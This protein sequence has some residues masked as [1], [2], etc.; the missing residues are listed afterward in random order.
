LTGDSSSERDVLADGKAEDIGRAG[1]SKTVDGDIVR[2]FLLL[3]EDE[4][5]EL[6]GVQNL[7]R[8]CVYWGQVS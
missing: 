8:L 5:L 2:D 1:K 6:R 7:A 4:V 3:L